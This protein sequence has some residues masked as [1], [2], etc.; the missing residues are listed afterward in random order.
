MRVTPTVRPS[1]RVTATVRPFPRESIQVIVKNCRQK[2]SGRSALV[3]GWAEEPPEQWI[4]VDSDES[5]EAASLVKLPILIELAR[6]I[7]L[8]EL[9]RDQKMVFE[10]RFRVG[11]SGVL[12]QRPA[13]EVC[14][15]EQLATWMIAES[16]N[17][18]TDMLLEKLG[19][20]DIQQ[21]IRKLGL[22]ATT[23][24]RTIFDFAA[25]DAGKDN[26]ISARDA[27]WILHEMCCKRLPGSDWMLQILE[28]TRR[29]DLLLGGL[30]PGLRVA[31][32][33]GQLEGFLH[34]AAVVLDRRP[35]LMVVL[36]AQSG[37]DEAR[38]FMQSLARQVY[39]ECLEGSAR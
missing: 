26:R 29:R 21:Q 3:L 27:A 39:A 8:G 33:T 20:A 18:A 12:Q 6:R 25:I 5:F 2:F 19:M 9:R 13:G 4:E 7:E 10:E 30:P 23:V 32:K 37:E 17:V 35:L 24:E 1:P 11:G 34:E 22:Q 14:S 16:D 31:H 28:K 15:L 36:T 38:L